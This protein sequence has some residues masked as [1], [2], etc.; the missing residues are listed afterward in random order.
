MKGDKKKY[1]ILLN[2]NS[3]LNQ[4]WTDHEQVQGR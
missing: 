2:H 1:A 3:K 4:I